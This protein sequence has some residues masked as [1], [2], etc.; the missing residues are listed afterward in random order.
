VAFSSAA[1]NLVPDDTNRAS[2][3]FVYD[4]QLGAVARVSVDST[5]WQANGSSGAVALAA[6][7]RFA[8]FASQADDLVML[9]TNG[10][11]DIFVHDLGEHPLRFFMPFIERG[12]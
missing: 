9:D 11:Q 7:G 10:V 5:G 3:V 2:D 1:S 8:V 6:S 12:S 4:R